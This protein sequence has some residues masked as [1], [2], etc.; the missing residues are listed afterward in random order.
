MPPE[1][2]D[3]TLRRYLLGLLPE[4]EAESL[5]EEYLARPE[6]LERLRGVEDDLL[7][8]Y[9]AGR[10]ATADIEPFERRYLSAPPLRQRVVSARALHLAADSGARG[11]KAPFRAI[12]TRPP[13]LALAAS[14]LLAVLAWFLWPAQA[15]TTQ[16]T[17]T[18]PPS[19]TVHHPTPAP[20]PSPLPDVSLPETSRVVLALSPVLLR[21]ESRPV[22]LK[23]PS[24]ATSVVLELQGDPSALPG[25]AVKLDGEIQT[26]EGARVW[27]GEARRSTDPGRAGRLASVT[28]PAS[29][30]PT[31][32]YLVTLAAGGEPLH[33]YFVRVRAVP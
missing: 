14:V 6:V 8:D 30:L 1:L 11:S 17:A 33:R 16:A 10:L 15:P 26:V 5:E 25:A 13:V 20:S 12:S 24:S 19:G 29:R 28:V 18:T 23:V 22:E 4:A 3:A 27:T 9:A 31:G 32:D 7:D 21:S 2:D